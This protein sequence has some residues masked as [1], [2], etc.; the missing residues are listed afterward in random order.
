MASL[1]SPGGS[2]VKRLK[3]G[4]RGGRPRPGPEPPGPSHLPHDPEHEAEDRGAE[5]DG[6]GEPLRAVEEEAAPGLAVEAVPLLDPEGPGEGEGQVEEHGEQTQDGEEEEAGPD[7]AEP[8]ALRGHP[9]P[10]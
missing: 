6:E 3:I 9:R 10:P 2:G 7:R 1:S 8:E 5:G 4:A